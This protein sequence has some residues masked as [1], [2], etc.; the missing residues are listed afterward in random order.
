P[1]PHPSAPL[2]IE[3]EEAEEELSGEAASAEAAEEEEEAAAEAEEAEPA[4]A[5]HLPVHVPRAD[6]EDDEPLAPAP[7]SNRFM[8]VVAGV[9][10]LLVMGITARAQ[11]PPGGETKRAPKDTPAATE[12][13]PVPLPESKPAPETQN[14]ASAPSSASA[15]A[16]SAP[17]SVA[18]IDP[19]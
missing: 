19:A 17:A 9:V 2:D 11:N 16:A 1:A 5:A 8:L 15:P 3:E 10:R 18:A 12:I 6:R 4:R 13:K 7:A 14:A